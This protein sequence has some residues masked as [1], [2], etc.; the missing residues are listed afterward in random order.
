MSSPVPSPTYTHIDPTKATQYQN[1]PRRQQDSYLLQSDR[2]VPTMPA[3]C[4]IYESKGHPDS[5]QPK[6]LPP[7]SLQP[8]KG[9]DN[10]C[11]KPVSG[12][13]PMQPHPRKSTKGEITVNQNGL[14]K[15]PSPP[16][17]PPPPN[18]PSKRTASVPLVLESLPDPMT[19][20]NATPRWKCEQ[21][22]T[23]HGEQSLFPCPT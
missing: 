2:P 9:A 7:P 18:T 23:C 11:N 16:P 14:S 10:Y 21:H 3:P 15:T 13:D 4:S 22:L 5:N 8:N 20:K 1:Q 6:T 19:D 12:P 17:P